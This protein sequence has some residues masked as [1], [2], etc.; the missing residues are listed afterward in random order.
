MQGWTSPDA[1][2]WRCCLASL[3]GRHP[4]EFLGAEPFDFEEQR[5]HLASRGYA[6]EPVW[7][8]GTWS[9]SYPTG[10]WI[11]LV[12]RGQ[13]LH[14]VVAKRSEVLLDPGFRDGRPG[15]L[16]PADFAYVGDRSWPLGFRVVRA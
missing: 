2:C 9:E 8:H 4:S 5:A 1:D 14:A 7:A 15:H 6:L 16:W 13:S 3:T 12:G 11:A 10:H